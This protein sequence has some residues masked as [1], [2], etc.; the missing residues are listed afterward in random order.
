MK[1]LNL[2]ALS[3]IA[4]SDFA[5]PFIASSCQS[6]NQK[7]KDFDAKLDSMY[8]EFQKTDASEANK[9]GAKADLNQY[10][11]DVKNKIDS[12]VDYAKKKTAEL[13]NQVKEEEQKNPKNDALISA[14]NSRIAT[15]KP[16]CDKKDIY[17]SLIIILD[18]QKT[19]IF[20]DW[21]SNGHTT[22]L[23]FEDPSTF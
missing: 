19:E 14:L 10:K 3:T 15:L 17:K 11:K 21:K 22:L 6:P 7:E 20:N 1:K 8:D 2:I 23:A 4:T 12:Y 5:F 18:T 13:Q 9:K 16:Y